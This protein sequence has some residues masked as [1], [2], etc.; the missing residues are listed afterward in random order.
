MGWNSRN[1]KW[2]DQPNF[3]HAQTENLQQ[4]WKHII[5]IL[6]LLPNYYLHLWLVSPAAKRHSTNSLS[7]SISWSASCQDNFWVWLFYMLELE[8]EVF[9]DWESPDSMRAEG[10]RDKHRASCIVP[11][12]LPPFSFCSL[13]TSWALSLPSCHNPEPACQ[14]H[15]APDSPLA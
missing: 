15:C 9:H 12:T 14:Q 1:N 5:L 11:C 8:P 7:P 2:K 6:N 13:P 3:S 4:A 10:R